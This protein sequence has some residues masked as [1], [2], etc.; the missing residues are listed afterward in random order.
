[1]LKSIVQSSELIT[2]LYLMLSLMLSNI[3]YIYEVIIE[4]MIIELSK[5]CFILSLIFV[6]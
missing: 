2:S 5:Q 4:S 1:M 3:A 6:R